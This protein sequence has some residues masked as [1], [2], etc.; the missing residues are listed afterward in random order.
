MCIRDSYWPIGHATLDYETIARWWTKTVEGTGVKLYIGMADY[1]A[2]KDDPEDPW[3]GLDGLKAQLALNRE[4]NVAGEAHF[5][6]KFLAVNSH[7]KDL[8]TDWYREGPAETGS[9]LSR[10]SEAEQNHWAAPYYGKLG[11]MGVVSGYPD[12]TYQMC[13]RDRAFLLWQ[14]V[15]RVRPMYGRMQAAIDLVNRV[16]QENLTAIRVVKAYVRGDYE[17]EKFHEVNTNLQTT[18]CLLYTSRCV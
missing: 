1:Q 4:L 14:I 16:V 18:A 2:D 10:L 13:I 11:D 6:Y 15:S 3:Y 7:L 9:F 17:K 5:R 12:G 8:Y